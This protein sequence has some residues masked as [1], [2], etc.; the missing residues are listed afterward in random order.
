M[1]WQ[2]DDMRIFGELTQYGD[3]ACYVEELT[4]GNKP[5]FDEPFNDYPGATLY[6]ATLDLT[7]C[8]NLDATAMTQTLNSLVAKNSSNVVTIKIAS[9]VFSQLTQAVIDAA[10]NKG[11]TVVSA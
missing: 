9:S 7:P 11:Y 6:N 10:T 1:Q 2:A 4:F 5:L 3:F 8:I